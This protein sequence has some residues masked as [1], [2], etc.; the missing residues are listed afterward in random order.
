MLAKY[1]YVAQRTEY[2]R[3]RETKKAYRQGQVEQM[4]IRCK[5]KEI[6]CLLPNQSSIYV[7]KLNLSICAVRSKAKESKRKR[8]A[9]VEKRKQKKKKENIKA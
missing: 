6:F 5:P 9:W 8:E 1:I 7:K 2:T 4:P 3:Y